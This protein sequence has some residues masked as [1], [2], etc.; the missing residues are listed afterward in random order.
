V[1]NLISGSDENLSGYVGER[2]FAGGD[3]S[4]VDFTEIRDILFAGRNFDLD[5]YKDRCIKRRIAARIRTLG[6]RQASE[7]IRLLAQQTEEQEKLL[8]ALTIHVSQFFRNPTT[9]RV[10]EETVLPQL[11]AR[12]RVLG[13]D[14]RVWSIGCAGGEEPYSVALLCDELC[15]PQDQVSIIGTDVSADILKKARAAVFEEHRLA[16][17]PAE[18]LQQYFTREGHLYRLSSRISGKVRFVRHDILQDRPMPRVDLILCRN[19]LIYFSRQEQE[20]ILRLLAAT[21]T[22]DGL[23]V[24]GRAETLVNESREFF[25]CVDASERIYRKRGTEPLPPQ[26]SA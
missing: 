15:S 11:L 17:V 2:R 7:Y 18:V 6:F 10:L 22:A 9:F 25:I 3:L 23:L 26:V 21:L 8:E 19:M 5:A 14:L 13:G 16:E 24:L 4:E 1:S 20:R 12:R